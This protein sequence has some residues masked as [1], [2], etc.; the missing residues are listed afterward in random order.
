MP[1]FGGPIY[2]NS[3]KVPTACEAGQGVDVDGKVLWTGGEARYV[4][5][6]EAGS[7]NPGVPPNLDAPAGTVWRLDVLA[8]KP[9]IAS[10]VP[11]GQTPAGSFQYLPESQPAVP[12]AQGKT[13]QLVAL[14]DV[15]IP[16]ANCIFQF[17]VPVPKPTTPVVPAPQPDA[18]SG[19]SDGAARRGCRHEQRRRRR[20][21]HAGRG[22][23]K[24]FG[25]PCTDTKNHTTALRR[26]LCSKSPSTPRAIAASAIA[27]GSERMPHR[28]ECSDSLHS[29]YPSSAPAERHLAPTHGSPAG[30]LAGSMTGS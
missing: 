9:P 24:G 5:V 14:M 23:A 21:V 13:Y 8:S 28:A 2:D 18:G 15:G 7:K 16:L 11:Y 1:P 10:G 6:L 29:G 17:G 19:Y 26:Q 3:V 20:G 12:L 27:R 25:A 30:L 4:Y 22:D